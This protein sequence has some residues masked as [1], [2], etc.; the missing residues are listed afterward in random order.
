M[1]RDDQLCSDY[2]G[3][4][5]Y[6]LYYNLRNALQQ[7]SDAVV[8]Y[9]GTYSNHLYALAKA[10]Q[11]LNLP[12]I[13]IVR[14][15]ESAPLT[16][17]LIDAVSCGMQLFFTDKKNYRNKNISVILPILKKHYPR[18]MLVPEGGDNLAGSRGCMAIASALAE[19]LEHVDNY[20]LCCATG[21]GAT[22]TGLIAASPPKS[23][24][25]GFSVLKGEDQLSDRVR[26]GLGLLGIDGFGSGLKTKQWNVQTG[27]HHGGYGRASAELLG[28]MSSFEDLNGLPLEPVYTAKMLWGIEKLAE[29]GYWSRGST[30]V[31]LHSGGLQ[32]RRGFDL[33]AA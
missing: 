29:A 15:Y 3:N 27:F 31:A 2:S 33:S 7:D 20:S 28:F 10:G 8:S 6:K 24:C 25:V 5:Y 16:P 26:R 32:G 22:L 19:Q 4:K 30:V 23:Q 11:A 21:T 17:T 1:R 12:T 14:G 18:Y 13:G 9:G